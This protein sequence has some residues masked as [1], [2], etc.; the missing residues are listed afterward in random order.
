VLLCHRTGSKKKSYVL[1]R[2]SPSAVAAHMRHGDKAPT[3]GSCTAANKVA[4]A[5]AKGKGKHHR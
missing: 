2:V 3:N 5:K 1:I 4:K